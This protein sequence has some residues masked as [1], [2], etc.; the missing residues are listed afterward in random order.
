MNPALQDCEFSVTVA[1]VDF[2][3]VPI[4]A[5]GKAVLLP[6][7]GE[8]RGSAPAAPLW[9]LYLTHI[10]ICLVALSA[11]NRFDSF[12]ILI[13]Y[14]RLRK[15][16]CLEE[17]VNSFP[18]AGLAV[19][20]TCLT[21]VPAVS[22]NATSTDD[23]L[24][25]AWFGRISRTQAE[26]P[27][28]ITPVFTTTPRLEEEFRYDIGRQDIAKGDV[29]NY[30]VSKG[31]EVIPTEH[32]EII[33]SPPPYIGH[34]NPKAHD[35]FGDMSFLLKYRF[36]TGNE[37]HGNYIVTALLGASIPT[38][39]YANGAPKAVVTPTFAFGKGWGNFDIQSTV[40]VGIPVGDPSRLGTPI[41]Y[42][43]VFQC[44]IFKKIWPEVEAN[45]AFFPNGPNS[46]NHQLFLSPGLVVG[47]L[48][49]YKRLGLTV[50][51]G[52]Q[53]AAT[54]F[55]TFNHNRALTIRFPF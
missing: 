20:L 22:Q 26:Q 33:I 6:S 27:H 18:L 53:I 47:R 55:H 28:W 35:G 43:T 49:L 4:T 51:G 40:G 23:G 36:S 15:E 44:R 13:Y 30:G 7:R 48:H 19:L 31:L 14:M 2:G 45:A 54:H 11:Y 9:K 34:D 5:E 38:G 1:L 12:S 3:S 41:A 42:N 25:A 10:S 21:T 52:V 39:S 8:N 37:E 24:L 17:P 50:G 32:T 46:G 16:C 29:R